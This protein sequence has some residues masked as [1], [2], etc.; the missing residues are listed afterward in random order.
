[1]YTCARRNTA[2][3]WLTFP[4]RTA[5]S[6][7]YLW[8]SLLTFRRPR[9]Y[10]LPTSPR[11]TLYQVCFSV[12][13]DKTVLGLSEI[14]PT[15]IACLKLVLEW[16]PP[17]YALLRLEA[18]NHAGDHPSAR[19]LLVLHPAGPPL[20]TNALSRMFFY[21][22]PYTCGLFSLFAVAVAVVVCMASVLIE[23]LVRRKRCI[24]QKFSME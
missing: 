11:G 9:N 6:V 23:R 24:V 19:R 20:F 10:T 13:K 15:W 8:L 14:R 22:L 17:L 12:V 5:V 3:S 7:C 4:P 16:E 21:T 1:M 18:P 2:N